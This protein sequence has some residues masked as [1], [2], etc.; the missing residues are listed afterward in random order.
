MKRDPSAS[1][2][3]P[4]VE[5]KVVPEEDM[6][7]QR[8]KKAAL[9]K[10]AIW[11][12]TW[13]LLSFVLSQPQIQTTAA[14]AVPENSWTNNG[15]V[16]AE[17]LQQVEVKQETRAPPNDTDDDGVIVVATVDGTLAGL[18]QRTGKTLWKQ[19]GVD[20]HSKDGDHQTRDEHMRP[21]NEKEKNGNSK[22]RLLSPLLS[23]TTTTQSSDFQY[24]SSA[25]RR[26]SCLSYSWA[27]SQWHP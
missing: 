6:K 2:L 13:V 27:R 12:H 17:T 25:F 24:S 19:S 16:E 15:G 8:R 9:L 22:N 18:S 26:W 20:S 11:I 1:S 14:V 21:N 10:K 23:T 3:L 5:A 7:P 4:V